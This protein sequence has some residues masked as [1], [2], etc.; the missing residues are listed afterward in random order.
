MKKTKNVSKY[1]L[2]WQIVRASVKGPKTYVSEKLAHV[3]RF[4]DNNISKENWE[5]VTNWLEGLVIAYKK[6]SRERVWVDDVLSRFKR[7]QFD[8]LP[9]VESTN[10]FTKYTFEQRLILWKDLALRTKVWAEKGYIHIEQT[11]FCV[12]L[13]KSFSLKEQEKISPNYSIENFERIIAS[14]KGKANTH[15]FLF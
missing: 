2:D 5:R 12:E 3:T 11:E 7:I 4:Y 1:D 10:D 9:S 15:I 6:N 14:A 13:W 8:K